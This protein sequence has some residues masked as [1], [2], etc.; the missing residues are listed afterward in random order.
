MSAMSCC[1]YLRPA[2]A[3]GFLLLL[4]ACGAGTFDPFGTSTDA[5]SS[6]PAGTSASAS[7]AKSAPKSGVQLRLSA[8]DKIR[9]IVFG[10]DKLSGEYQLD[11]AGAVSLPLAGTVEAAGLTKP[12][13]EQAL[14]A[15]LKSEYLRNPK[16]TVDVISFRPFYVLG[17]VS[18]PGEYPYR[19]GL[20]VLSAIAIAGGATYRANNSVVW[21][22]RA[23]TNEFAE[24]PQS[25]TILVMP[26]DVLR[27]RERY[28]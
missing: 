24:Y 9:V 2:A 19:S 12:E 11:T 18:R 27:L 25:P 20:N 23:G 6:A 22:Q 8:G 13:L 15:K 21:I 5:A 17:E 16:V 3:L 28:F 10:E 1:S 26:G 7:T 4:S 14:T